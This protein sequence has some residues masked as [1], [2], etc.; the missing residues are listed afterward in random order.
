MNAL[1]RGMSFLIEIALNLWVWVLLLRLVL[2][3]V[4]AS[5]FNPLSQVLLRLTEWLIKPSRKYLR[6]R[7]W[8]GFDC[9]LIIWLLIFSCLGVWL[10][11]ILGHWMSGS[12]SLVSAQL[13]WW[14]AIFLVFI[15]GLAFLLKHLIYLFFFAIL[16]RVFVSWVPSAMSSPLYPLLCKLTDPLLNLFKRV[17]PSIGGIDFSPLFALIALQL[18]NV[19]VFGGW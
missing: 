1:L 11:N 17:I 4:G 12:A 9:A 18:V 7:H 15:F 10:L 2:Q 3:K 8:K 5:Y 14:Q 19:V 16:I 6:L 13:P